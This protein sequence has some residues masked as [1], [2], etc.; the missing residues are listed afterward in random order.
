MS[1]A[2]RLLVASATIEWALWA[3]GAVLVVAL[4]VRARRAPPS[5]GSPHLGIGHRA[6]RVAMLAVLA[7]ALLTRLGGC[8]SP[9][10]PRNYYAQ[11]SVVYA[12]D[13]L[14]AGD[15]GRRWLAQLGN[16]QVFFEHQ[17]PI[18]AP[19]TVA[20]QR[21]LGPSI[22]LPTIVGAL[23]GTLAVL[24]AWAV[25]RAVESPAFGILFAAFVAVSPLQIT[26]SRI[27]G[28]HIGA[29]P[30]VLFAVWSGWLVGVRGGIVSGLL[31]G[32]VAWSCV[33][34]YFAA[35]VG[36]GLAFVAL[37]A[38]WRRSGRGVGRLA[39]LTAAAAVGLAACLPAASC[40][41]SGAV[42]V[43]CGAGYVGS[44]ARRRGD[45][46]RSA[47][48]NVEEQTR[49]A[50][51]GLLLARSAWGR[52]R[53][54]SP[55]HRRP[56]PAR[57]LAPGMTGGGLLLLPVLFLGA[58]GL[59]GCLRHP[60]ERG[61]W[62]GLALAGWLPAVLSVPT[63]RRFLVFDLGWCAFAAFGLRSLLESR[64]L[65]PARASGRWRWGGAVLGGTALWSAA[66]LG[67]SWMSAPS[68]QAFIPFGESG[69]GD[70]NTCLGCIRTGR[71]WQQEIQDGRMVV[72]FDTDV[73]RE[74][75]TMPGGVPLYGKTAALAARH[76]RRFLDFY[77]VA[78]NYDSEPPRPG[79]LASA[80]PDDVIGAVGA[81]DRGGAARRDRVVVHAA[82][83]VGA[84]AHRRAGAGWL[85]PHLPAGGADVGPRPCGRRGSADPH[86]DAVGAT[87]RMR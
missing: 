25:G 80:P 62:L 31:L 26:W 9:H 84:D 79:P 46:V 75:A 7:W 50:L 45:W 60:V 36:M 55:R 42:A 47:A 10:Q 32:V 56:G 12:A 86:R 21:I 76:P 2:E 24:L 53:R 66:A 59:F 61:L 49:R 58:V 54:G 67:L 14:R 70:G 69:F 73:Y 27:G 64:L 68:Q 83:R 4:L 87:A 30:A 17:S 34:F 52:S 13:A 63:A 85:E 22:E 71:I 23:W 44:R 20:L 48:A 51:P 8:A 82:E 72:M 74:N 35:R 37:C 77:A 43:A 78:S 39:G 11:I 57:L 3:L 19:V 6:E 41:A 65:N 81:R 16:V 40:R 29:S 18:Q 1:P 5:P 28:I 38:G 15:L 33:Y